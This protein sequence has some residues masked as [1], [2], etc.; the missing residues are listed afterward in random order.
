MAD[1][2]GSLEKY[3]QQ[4]AD[5]AAPVNALLRGAA[6][7]GAAPALAAVLARDAA[8]I[9][10]AAAELR[11][12]GGP[13]FPAG[14]TTA[15]LFAAALDSLKRFRAAATEA[16]VSVRDAVTLFKLSG[17]VFDGAP[18]ARQSVIDGGAKAE[19]IYAA[20]CR[21]LAEDVAKTL[22]AG[23]P[24]EV[25][26][27][28]AEHREFALLVVSA[29]LGL[30]GGREHL[31]DVRGDLLRILRPGL[32]VSPTSGPLPFSRMG[33]E[34]SDRQPPPATVAWDEQADPLAYSHKLLVDAAAVKA[35]GLP[36][37]LS[38]GVGVGTITRFSYLAPPA[39]GRTSGGGDPRDTSGNP[40]HDF[41][42]ANSAPNVNSG[43]FHGVGASAKPALVDG[44]VCFGFGDPLGGQAVVT[45]SLPPSESAKY[46]DLARDE[47]VALLTT[48][49]AERLRSMV[50]QW[51]DK[52]FY[53]RLPLRAFLRVAKTDSAAALAAALN[54]L[55]GAPREERFAGIAEA[56]AGT[57][58]QPPAWLYNAAETAFRESAT[59][60]Q[61]YDRDKA[62]V[63][64]TDEHVVRG[65]QVHNFVETFAPIFRA[66]WG[67][68]L[69]FKD[70][71]DARDP[72]LLATARL[73]DAISIAEKILGARRADL[74]V[75]REPFT[76]YAGKGLLV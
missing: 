57:A 70:F 32:G 29:L 50:P 46:N 13:A 72:G 55:T 10:D 42:N 45:P 26:R 16:A 19:E 15:Q 30:P 69:P 66:R 71:D 9:G 61:R 14:N 59:I 75:F 43:E 40:G 64:A 53:E 41:A 22:S 3:A 60:W 24:Q 25:P 51:N 35:A 68:V 36:L 58:R 65:S 37:N 31:A 38:R 27:F 17:S 48:P 34:S 5:A 33:L 1:A 23:A 6:L 47:I 18:A 2:R 74:L 73:A 12:L 28:L 56:V 4:I 76:L 20:A 7:A 62:P 11:R 39:P 63:L 49:T 44:P 21:E 8:A 67:T 52:R 54:A